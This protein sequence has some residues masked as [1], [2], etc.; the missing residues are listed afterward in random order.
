MFEKM[1]DTI[2]DMIHHKFVRT[3]DKPASPPKK[4][5][6]SGAR[7]SKKAIASEADEDFEGKDETP[8]EVFFCENSPLLFGVLNDLA[9]SHSKIPNAGLGMFANKDLARGEF[10]GEYVGAILSE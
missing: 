10:I 6:Q 8:P 7:R 4:T 5:S 1:I 2:A 3:P 9:L